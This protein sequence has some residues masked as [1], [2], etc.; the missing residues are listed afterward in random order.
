MKL[1]FVNVG[2][3][4][5]ILLECP[6]PSFQNGTFV[7][8]IDG[9]S[10][11]INEY[12]GNTSGRI[13]LW[14]YLAEKK[15]DHI[16]L[17]V[18]THPHADHVCS[19]LPAAKMLTPAAL[20]Q[21]I[22]ARFCR[23]VMRPLDASLAKN[24]SQNTFTRALNDCATLSKLVEDAGGAVSTVTAGDGGTL[25]QDLHYR[26]LSPTKARQKELLAHLERIYNA[27]D[28]TTYLSRLWELDEILNNFSIMLA[29]EYRGTRILLPG[30]TNRAGYGDVD[31]AALP[32]HLF[33]VGHHGQKDG[34]SQ[35]LLDIIRPDM[36]VCCA[37]SDRRYNS[38]HPDLM[39]RI[40]A[41]GAALYFSD[42]PQLPGR[43]PPPHRALIFTV[44]EQG[45]IR[46]QYE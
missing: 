21:T 5:A 25:C 15:L 38:A 2:Y 35:E 7:M 33:K 11:D 43:T 20:W 39:E 32:A 27:P 6:D 46:A 44:G 3:G 12:A 10:D 4:E 16:D 22:P 41:S 34:V 17:M 28:K 1:T 45:A 9:G 24:P 37:S 29:L 30:D 14:E 40:E 8:L 23:E 13:P 31:A 18:N 36:V 19:M 42:C 26:V